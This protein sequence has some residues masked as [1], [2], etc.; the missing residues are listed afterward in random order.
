MSVGIQRWFLLP[1]IG[2]AI[3]LLLVG[4]A[5]FT[6]AQ[7]QES[8]D[9]QNQE[10]TD[11]KA[12]DQKAA[13]VDKK[14]QLVEANSTEA[15][16]TPGSLSA[17]QKQ[18]QKGALPADPAALKQAKDQTA[19]K[20]KQLSPESSSSS[21]KDVAEAEKP[22]DSKQKEQTGSLATVVPPTQDG[23]F[24]TGVG[25]SDSTGA[26]GTTRYIEL[27]N[28]RVRI[29]TKAGGFLSQG[30]LT[31]L[32]GVASTDNV[33]DPQVIWDGRT[34]RF[35]YVMDDVVS[36]SDNR[37]A[38]GFSK[39]ASPN[40]AADFCHYRTSSLGTRFPDYPKLGDTANRVMIGVNSFDTIEGNF[41]GSDLL[42]ITKPAAGTTCP[43]PTTFTLGRITN[44]SNAFTPVPANQTDSSTTGFGVARNL[45]LPSSTL[46]VYTVFE[47]A[48]TRTFNLS[49]RN[50]PVAKYDV[51]NNAPQPGT[52][53][54][55][56]DTSDARPT[57]AVSAFDPLRGRVSIW[58]QHTVLGGS[59]ASVRWYEINPFTST[60]SLFQQ[61]NINGTSG[62]HVFNGAISPNRAVRTGVASRF[63]DSM[64]INFNTSAS[65][66][67]P[68]IRVRSKIGN[69]AL[70]PSVIVRS[71]PA[72]L[73]DFTCN[74]PNNPNVCRWG[75][76]AAATPDPLPLSSDPRGRVWSTNQF[77]RTTGS[78]SS[79]GWGTRNFAARP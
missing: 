11:Q 24:D 23:A 35:Y 3:L 27:V 67:R 69:G 20:A 71:S 7:S 47:N 5:S 73:N 4:S 49:T 59:G 15:A 79:S 32:G 21:S 16:G 62:L 48:T 1:A 52:N 61:Q 14:L 66:Q 22:A 33:F 70:V 28:E 41:V 31:Q 25:P 63:G 64:V 46:K 65:I 18:A 37:L 58:T 42:S 53:S 26:A 12:A 54:K 29:L 13:P 57:Q 10:S 34:N 19:Q 30:T 2:I 60:P 51:P 6:E 72:S 74:D 39:T 40:S 55:V 50:L 38:F 8:T 56:I 45:S 77:V 43:S 78:L 76:Y 75:D 36:S 68:D 9:P 17:V 44:L